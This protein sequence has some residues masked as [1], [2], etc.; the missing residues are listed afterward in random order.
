MH[1]LFIIVIFCCN[2]SKVRKDSQSN[3]LTIRIV[4]IELE[5]II[6]NK[7]WWEKT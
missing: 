3:L 4:H 7:T 1:D 2:I 6:G 5:D